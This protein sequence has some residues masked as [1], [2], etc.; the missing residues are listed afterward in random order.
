[1]TISNPAT[2]FSSRN[3]VVS[4]IIQL[5]SL[6]KH[7]TILRQHRRNDPQK[8][9]LTANEVNQKFIKMSNYS[10]LAKWSEFVYL[11]HWK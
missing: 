5:V 2:L 3:S 1:M 6:K 7:L 4:E 10:N 11:D 9:L 8:P